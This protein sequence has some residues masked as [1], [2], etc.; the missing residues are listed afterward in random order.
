[1]PSPIDYHH[2]T[3]PFAGG[4]LD[5][6]DALRNQPDALAALMARADGLVIPL[7]RDMVF[8][9][10]DGRPAILDHSALTAL[11]IIDP[12][13]VLLGL[14]GEKKRPWLCVSLDD[15]DRT[16]QD[17]PLAGLG[18]WVNLRTAAPRFEAKDL[19]IIGRASA[20][21]GWHGRH[22]FCANCGALTTADGGGIKRVCDPC[23]TEHF[24]RVDPVVIMLAE[25]DGHCLMGR[26][27]GWPEGMFSALAGFVEQ[28]ESLEEACVREIGEEA[29]IKIGAVRY[30]LSQPWPFPSSLMIGL[31]AQGLSEDITLDD[32]LEEARWFSRAEVTAMLAGEHPH[33][34]APFPFAAASYLLHEWVGQKVPTS[35]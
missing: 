33:F 27:S 20:L 16:E 9:L 3:L 5:R 17:F 32:E 22:R 21:L 34:S 7:W 2:L 15:D 24:P 23:G 29:G 26:Q 8:M 6:I 1:M 13:P 14:E 10:N 4:H 25:R 30:V 11:N 35:R 31:I 28:G 19:A 18:E 12:G